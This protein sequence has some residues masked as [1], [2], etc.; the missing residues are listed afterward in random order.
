A[1]TE[2]QRK[3]ITEKEDYLLRLKS[4]NDKNTLLE[5]DIGRLEGLRIS[6]EDKYEAREKE[7]KKTETEHL[8]SIETLRE[9]NRGIEREYK[10]LSNTVRVLQDTEQRLR[11]DISTSESS[12]NETSDKLRISEQARLNIQKDLANLERDYTG[13]SETLSRT[14]YELQ[15]L[16]KN[17]KSEQ[18]EKYKYYED[19]KNQVSKNTGLQRQLE[20]SALKMQKAEEENKFSAERLKELQTQTDIL[21]KENTGLKTDKFSLDSQTVQLKTQLEIAEKQLADRETSLSARIADLNKSLKEVTAERESIKQE[22]TKNQNARADLEKQNQVLSD[23]LKTYDKELAKIRGDNADLQTKLAKGEEARTK[24]EREVN[25]LF[26][27]LKTT[28]ESEQKYRDQLTAIQKSYADSEARLKGQTTKNEQQVQ[29]LNSAIKDLNTQKDSQDKLIAEFN[30]TIKSLSKENADQKSTLSKLEKDIKAKTSELTALQQTLQRER[31]MA[32]SEKAAYEENRSSNEEEI[33]SLKKDVSSM[34]ADNNNLNKQIEPLKKQI[35]DKEAQLLTLSKSNK[36]Y[37]EQIN[38]LEK[39]LTKSEDDVRKKMTEVSE[40]LRSA[41]S[42][43]DDINTRLK[44]ATDKITSLEKDIK[45]YEAANKTLETKYESREKDLRI[46]EAEYQKAVSELKEAKTNIT[47]LQK[48]NNDLSDSLKK[49]QDKTAKSEGLYAQKEDELRLVQKTL[50]ETET[51]N[52]ATVNTLQTQITNLKAQVGDLSGSLKTSMDEKD[53]IKD[54]K[55]KAES[56]L[57]L[58]NKNNTDLKGKYD[59]LQKDISALLSKLKTQ[60]YEFNKAVKEEREGYQRILSELNSA[61]EN[62]R[63][64]TWQIS[65]LQTR[66][67]AL[68][69][70]AGSLQN[71]L[72]SQEADMQA[73][74]IYERNLKN[75]Y[76]AKLDETERKLNTYMKIEIDLRQKVSTLEKDIAGIKLTLDEKIAEGIRK[77]ETD[78]INQLRD[79]NDKVK[80]MEE[81]VTAERVEMFGKIANALTESGKYDEAINCYEKVLRVNAKN[82][83]AYYNMGILYDERLDNPSRAIF[84]YTKYLE[85]APPDA[86]DRERVTKWIENC[87]KRLKGPPR[88]GFEKK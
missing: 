13:I 50:K 14:K 57:V 16:D 60:E 53:K 30:E 28:S 11:A 85:L 81:T 39:H 79:A 24:V 29:T 19:Y 25:V 87:Q 61:K 27:T 58:A 72:K 55:N 46:S 10:A 52:T 78:F 8:K 3:T 86:L 64:A 37:S 51:Q 23:T 47:A 73:T 26:T 75:D 45:S 4:A 17:L 34:R 5:K 80:I 40:K 18:A 83:S 1:T 62:L 36:D 65:E 20:T 67:T 15:I 42:E 68:D 41:T 54:E 70:S 69:K 32:K 56:N 33:S 77:K 59:E 71:Q 49:T 7:S 2:E 76:M 9:T 35:K 38:S 66:N 82:P 88:S 48:N 6:L 63:S 31:E 21:R 44:F 84:C 74:I 43:K 22:N 12:K